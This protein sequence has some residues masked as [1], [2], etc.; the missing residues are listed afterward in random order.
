MKNN[1]CI[2]MHENLINGKK[3]I[4]QTCQKPEIRWGKNGKN[5]SES[6]CFFD[7]ILEYGWRNFSHQILETNLSAEQADEREVYYIQLYDTTNSEKGYNL[8]REDE[9]VLQDIQ[10]YN[11]NTYNKGKIGY[12]YLCVETGEVFE[13]T[14]LAAAYAGLVAITGISACCRGKQ[15]HAGRHPV[16]KEKLS[17]K[18]CDPYGNIIDAPPPRIL[19]NIHNPNSKKVKC[20]ETGQIF[21]TITSAIAWGNCGTVGIQRNIKGLQKSAGKHPETGEKLHWEYVTED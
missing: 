14:K 4:G 6:S 1:Y 5:Y 17:W 21:N 10:N 11:Y 7:G 18:Y 9:Q 19:N 15:K 20:I 3:Y 12:C 8:K 2:Y 16:T 13:T